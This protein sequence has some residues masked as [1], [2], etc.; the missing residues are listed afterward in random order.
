MW[1]IAPSEFWSMPPR[2]WW[3]LWQLRQEQAEPDGVMT[4][5]EVA[6][7]RQ[8]AEEMKDRYVNN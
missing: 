3:W 4:E 8:W 6:D 7:L 2:E 1:E 5:Q